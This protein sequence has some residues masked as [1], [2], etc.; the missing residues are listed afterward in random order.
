MSCLSVSVVERSAC[1]RRRLGSPEASS[2][3]RQFKADVTEAEDKS[4]VFS[5]FYNPLFTYQF[6]LSLSF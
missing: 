3:S 6:E 1:R 4:G 2:P 5:K